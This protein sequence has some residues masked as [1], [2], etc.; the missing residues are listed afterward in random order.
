MLTYTLR[1]LAFAVP[2]LLAISFIIFAILDLAPSDPTA[3]LPLTIP[4]E[5]REKI[6]MSLGLGEPF[7][8]RYWKWLIQFFVNEPLNLIEQWTPRHFPNREKEEQMFLWEKPS[9]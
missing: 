6:R 2:A 7:A 8:V 1:R 5:V 4:P 9:S 3:Q